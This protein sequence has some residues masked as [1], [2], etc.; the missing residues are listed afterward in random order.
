MPPING[1]TKTYERLKGS[2]T[3]PDICSYK[4]AVP[5]IADLNDHMSLRLEYMKDCTAAMIK[6]ETIDKPEKI[7]EK[8]YAG[9]TFSTTKGINFFIKF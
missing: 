8:I 5:E 2:F 3:R 1:D 6:G 4:I 9:N 7:Y